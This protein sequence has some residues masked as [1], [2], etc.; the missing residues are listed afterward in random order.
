MTDLVHRRVAEVVAIIQAGWHRVW[1]DD[2]A[3]YKHQRCMSRS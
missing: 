3:I 1:V 2:R